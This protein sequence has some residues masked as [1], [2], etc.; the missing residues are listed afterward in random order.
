MSFVVLPV[1]SVLGVSDY[2]IDITDIRPSV[3]NP[4]VSVALLLLLYHLVMFCDV[5][6][7]YLS[8]S[9]TAMKIDIKSLFFG[10]RDVM[11]ERLEFESMV[12][13]VAVVVAGGDFVVPN[14]PSQFVNGI[15]LPLLPSFLF[16]IILQCFASVHFLELISTVSNNSTTCSSPRAVKT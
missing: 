8:H 1:P 11:V 12:V 4:L 6:M 13:V 3:S 5:G 10:I 15:L 14:A 7:R 16:E 9:R 2:G